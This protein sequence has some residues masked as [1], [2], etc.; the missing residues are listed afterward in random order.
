MK[1]PQLVIDTNVII[2]ALRSKRGA[3]AKL[4]SLLGTGLFDFHLSVPLVL[5][6]EEV[7]LRQRATLN[8]TDDEVSD[9]IDSL[10]TLAEHHKIHFL[11]RP[12]LR[13]EDDAFVLELAVAARCN[14]IVTYNVKD[15]GGVEQFGI[16]AISPKTFLQMI[17]VIS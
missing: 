6:Y 15:F 9:F 16:R 3:S 13:D 17:G 4:L 2:A 11:W 12:F 7:I 1:A 10:C 5:E 8:L 14:Y